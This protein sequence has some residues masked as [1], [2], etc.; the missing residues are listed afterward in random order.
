MSRPLIG[1]TASA[2]D[3]PGI[4]HPRRFYANQQYADALVE[5]GAAVILIPFVTDPA[6]L[7]DILDGWLIPGGGDIDASHYGEAN[8]PKS[9]HENPSRYPFEKRLFD[10]ANPAMPVL[11]ICYGCQMINVARGGSLHQHL[12]DV[13]GH[14]ENS[15]GTMQSYE[16]DSGSQVADLL[17]SAKVEGK[18]YHHQAINRLGDGL[19]IVG[20]D[21]DG[22]VEAI[23]DAEGR[24]LVGVQWHPERTA[25]SPESK[26]L[27]RRFVEAAAEYRKGRMQ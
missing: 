18:S 22:G 15:G 9:D 25:G 8:H 3:W 10:L 17:G 20:H 4:D 12:P 16:F 24:W 19:N 27:F 13:L 2:G 6:D 26:R 23:E 14:D 21:A 5:A 7:V 11:G 1:I